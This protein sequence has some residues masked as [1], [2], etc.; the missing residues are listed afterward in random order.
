MSRKKVDWAKYHN[1]HSSK[2]IWVIKLSFCQNDPTIRQSFW[3]KDSLICHSYSFWTMP[4][5]I[6]PYLLLSPVYFFSGHT[7]LWS[8]WKQKQ[9]FLPASIMFL[10]YSWLLTMNISRIRVKKGNQ[11][12]KLHTKVQML[13]W[14]RLQFVSLLGHEMSKNIVVNSLR[15]NCK[16][17]QKIVLQFHR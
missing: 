12:S 11:D 2:S 1:R 3:L 5:M 17:T 15:L 6:F 16:S 8:S 10:V 7:L 14:P 9:I 4:I 13:K